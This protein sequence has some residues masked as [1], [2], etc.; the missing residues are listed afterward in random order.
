MHSIIDNDITLPVML[1]LWPNYHHDISE[2]EQI[3]DD[4]WAHE[5][6][7]KWQQARAWVDCLDLAGWKR[8]L[9]IEA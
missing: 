7:W 1:M 6:T 2:G 9:L 8:W 5:C 3:Y 4:F